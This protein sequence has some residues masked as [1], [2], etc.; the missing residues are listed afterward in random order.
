VRGLGIGGVW[1]AVALF[2]GAGCGDDRGGSESATDPRTTTASPEASTEQSPEESCAAVLTDPSQGGVCDLGGTHAEVTAA[3][4]TLVADDVGVRLLS[5]RMTKA[6]AGSSELPGEKAQGTFAVLKLK[7]TNRGDK[8]L[9]W[10]NQL[11]GRT[12]LLVGEKTFAHNGDAEFLLPGEIDTVGTPI[13]PDG[14]QTR[15]MVYDVT[16]PSLSELKSGHALLGVLSTAQLE[17]GEDLSSTGEIALL[18]LE[19]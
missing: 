12:T 16:K 5:M 9:D 8:P 6:I 10:G 18:H 17:A 11:D 2:V 7:I 13:P 19:R 4:K 15:F 1:I 3:G 14:T